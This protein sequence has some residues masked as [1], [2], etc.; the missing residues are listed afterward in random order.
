[1]VI[2]YSG[3][4]MTTEINTVRISKVTNDCLVLHETF[5]KFIGTKIYTS[6]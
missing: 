1:M 4:K 2:A 3:L 5:P 6:Q